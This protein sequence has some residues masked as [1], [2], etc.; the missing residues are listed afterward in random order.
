MQFKCALRLRTAL[1]QWTDIFDE[2]FWEKRECKTLNAFCDCEKLQ[3]WN[4]WRFK[5]PCVVA[6]Y[7]YT[8]M[9]I[10]VTISKQLFVGVKLFQWKMNQFCMRFACRPQ[11]VHTLNAILTTNTSGDKSRSVLTTKSRLD[12][13]VLINLIASPVFTPLHKSF[14]MC[15]MLTYDL[16]VTSSIIVRNLGNAALVQSNK[17]LL[18]FFKPLKNI[19]VAQI[20]TSDH[21]LL[22]LERF[23]MLWIA[24]VSS[25]SNG[26]DCPC[27]VS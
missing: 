17:T 11:N 19:V 6:G 16:N 18:Q 12:K 26:F 25:D 5:I 22:Q 27:F 1:W 15:H 13:N 7:H 8:N 24:L 14:S 20:S 23:W 9:N 2:R 3:Q 21:I 10:T 4:K